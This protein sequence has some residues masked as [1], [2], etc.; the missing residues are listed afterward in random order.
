MAWW[1]ISSRSCRSWRRSSA[2]VPGRAR[3]APAHRDRELVAGDGAR[4]GA[5][6]QHVVPRCGDHPRQRPRGHADLLAGMALPAAGRRRRRS[7]ARRRPRDEETGDDLA[8]VRGGCRRRSSRA[9]RRQRPENGAAAVARLAAASVSFGS[10]SETSMSMG[11]GAR[12]GTAAAA[13]SAGGAATVR[14]PSDASTT[15]AP[16]RLRRDGR[17][18]TACRSPSA[19]A[20]P[21]GRPGVSA[22]RQALERPLRRAHPEAAATQ[23]GPGGEHDGRRC[24]RIERASIGCVPG[25]ARPGSV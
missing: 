4:F 14:S 12:P 22:R 25:A 11:A 23:S 15:A 5:A 8:A 21:A 9:R 18:S 17:G 2:D 6:N 10:A 20:T 16:D 7:S 13:G 24:G 1:A 3:S 19:R